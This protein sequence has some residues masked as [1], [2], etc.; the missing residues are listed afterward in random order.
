MPGGDASADLLVV[1]LGNPGAS[2]ARTRH[3]VGWMCVEE[4][5]RRLGVPL[6]RRRWS[7]RV[8]VGDVSSVDE[9]AAGRLWLVLPQTM[10][11]LSGSAVKSAMRD[12]RVPL[13]SV[14]VVYDELDLPFCRLRIRVGG[15]SAGHRG[16]ASIIASV[17]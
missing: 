4:L 1:G 5:A 11:N 7:S 6:G 2:Y 12:L 16:V 9:L 15:S 8:G 13:S 17:G 10:M 14:W 3:N